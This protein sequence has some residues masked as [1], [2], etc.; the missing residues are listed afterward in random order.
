MNGKRQW[1]PLFSVPAE[2]MH[3]SLEVKVIHITA[4]I[5]NVVHE[6][7]CHANST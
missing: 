4:Y 1:L 5:E 6:H 2:F 7:E 3:G